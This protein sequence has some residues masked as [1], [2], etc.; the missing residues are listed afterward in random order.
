MLS[1]SRVLLLLLPTLLLPLAAGAFQPFFDK[2]PRTVHAPEDPPLTDF[3]LEVLQLCGDWGAEVDAVDFERMMLKP[4]NAPVVERLR[5]ALDSRIY[6]RA[7]DSE[8]FV[9]ELR[10]VWFE[11]KGFKHV[12]CGE[13]G[14]G[15]DLG[16]LHYAARYWQAQD[17]GWAG[18]RRLNA[19]PD[20]RPEYKCRAFYL[21]ERIRPPIYSI[22]VEFQNPA[23]PQN[24]VKCLTGYHR[25]MNAEE[26]LLAG[27][28]AF[29]LVNERVGK[30]SKE[31]CL[32]ETR[33]A[34][35]E[36]FY[37]TFVIKQ[38]ALRT[39]Y[40]LAEQTPYCKKNKRDFRDCLCSNL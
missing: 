13:P 26:I 20:A 19:N 4:A 25:E 9:R 2:D 6:T 34:G 3:D 37:S 30:N 31:G 5:N 7:N 8:Q 1:I 15:Q 10:R 12:F 23:E 39:F 21:K 29:T 32:F 33:L 38:R 36:P 17:K 14:E 24:N 11:Q 40:P 27:T 22:S 18:Y 16:G 35:K 28:Q